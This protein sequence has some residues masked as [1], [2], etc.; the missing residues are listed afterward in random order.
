MTAWAVAGA[1]AL[2]AGTIAAPAAA[3]A[4]PAQAEIDTV[5]YFADSYP[6][7]GAGSVFETVTFERFEYLLGL[8]GRFAFLIGGPDDANTVASISA[9][10]EVAKA[11]GVERI[12]NFNPKLDGATLDVRTS[13]DPVVAALWA[14]LVTNHLSKDTQTPF[15][16]S[17]E[18]SLFV[19]DKSHT[20]SGLEDRIVSA[21]TRTTTVN[22]LADPTALAS[23]KSEVATVLGSGAALNTSSQFS[24]FSTAVNAKHLADYRG[25]PAYGGDVLDETDSDFRLQGVTYP[26]LVNIL[27]SEGDY[28]ILLGG[29]WCHNTRA[30]VKDVNRQAVATGVERIYFFDLRL[31][32]KSS[33]NLHIR[34]TASAYAHLYGDLVANYLP[35]LRTQ[36]DVN[37]DAALSQRVSYKPGGDSNAATAKVQKLQVPYL[38]EY[39]KGRTSNGQAAPIVQQWIKDNGNGSYKEFMTEW[40]YVL[41]LPGRYT[42]PQDPALL[43]Q[44]AFADEAITALGTFF[45][46]LPGVVVAPVATAPAAPAAPS[47]TVSGTTVTVNWA[48]PADGGSA[49]TGYSVALNGGTPVVLPSGATSHSFTGL[50]AGSYT[51]TVAATNAIGSSAASAAS[52]PVVVA[53]PVVPTPQPVDPTTVKGSVSVTGSFTPGGTITVNG[54]GLAASANGFSVEIHSTPQKLGGVSTSTNGTFS[55]TV[56][57]PASVP[58]GA[59]SI[60]VT[61]DGVEVARTAITV[62]AATASAP[63][64]LAS[65]G[66]EAVAPLGW[67][68]VALLAAGIAAFGF[69]RVRARRVR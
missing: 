51:A 43:A 13:T 24:F 63:A 34:D 26:E 37:N 52:A 62:K 31:D 23:Y 35:N 7:L 12:Y 22:E 28:T 67:L 14:R 25:A 33:N 54:T 4:A 44:H 8:D 19:Y 18:P 41:D 61:I 5:D 36:Y 45:R 69:T 55:Y 21:V 56:V 29:T 6:G 46:A 27:K 17:D 2:F 68:A 1:T 32:G 11:A 47:A 60:V 64:G 20:E 40:W 49:I 66:V 59:H 9:I 53:A 58:L 42:N 38:F 48:A 57:I 16:G 39:K 50:S 65:T 30:V 10:N 3:I 15:D